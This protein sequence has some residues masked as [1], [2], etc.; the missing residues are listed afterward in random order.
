MHSILNAMESLPKGKALYVFH[1]RIPVFLLPELA[2]RDFAFRVREVGPDE[3][4]LIIY[5]Q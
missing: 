4:H 1:K 5:H 2:A 3:V